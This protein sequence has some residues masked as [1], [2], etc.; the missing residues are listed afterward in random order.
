[1]TVGRHTAGGGGGRRGST[2]H[3]G[4]GFGRAAVDE[5]RW[6]GDSGGGGVTCPWV[7]GG[8][9]GAAGRST[10]SPGILVHAGRLVAVGTAGG[11]EGFWL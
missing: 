2:G 9:G 5:R 4:W 11:L 6:R 8:K 10:A 7:H 3:L 1:M